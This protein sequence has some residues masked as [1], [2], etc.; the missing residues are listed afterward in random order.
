MQSKH[1]RDIFNPEPAQWG[2][3]GDPEL[4]RELNKHFA[5]LQE[6]GARMTEEVFARELVH[7]FEALVGSPLLPDD[8]TH[9]DRYESKGMSGGMVSHNFWIERGIPMLKERFKNANA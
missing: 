5:E 3:R 9:I 4:W 1:L 7:A 2:L 6:N 8:M